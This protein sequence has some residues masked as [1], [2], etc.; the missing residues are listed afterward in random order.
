MGRVEKVVQPMFYV[1]LV[2]NTDNEQ[3]DQ[4]DDKLTDE[5]GKCDLIL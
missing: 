3:Q 4:R 2:L 5:E 1:N